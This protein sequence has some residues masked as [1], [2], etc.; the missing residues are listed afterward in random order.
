VPR[1]LLVRHATSVPPRPGGPDEASRPLSHR[2]LAEAARLTELLAPLRPD[3]IVSS[4]YLRAVQTVEPLAADLGLPVERN[5]ELREWESG[6]DPRPD[7]EAHYRWSLAHPHEARGP[8]ESL[9][10]LCS[11]A[12]RALRAIS[13]GLGLDGAA[14]VAS[15][16]TWIARALQTFGREVDVEDW[17]AMPSPSVF[18]IET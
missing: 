14:V 5:R 12:M 6:L 4:P 2:G 17:L 7:W 18:E 8:G 1:L 11:R 3:R 13:L 15:H 10:A 16:G 9:T